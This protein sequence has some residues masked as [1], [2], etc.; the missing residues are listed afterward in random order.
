MVAF[1]GLIAV[2]AILEGGRLG[3]SSGIHLSLSLCALLFLFANL[4]GVFE[5]SMPGV[6]T[7][8]Q[9]S[10]AGRQRF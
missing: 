6:Q 3:F 2:I 8:I 7:G 5:I 1:A 4:L 10:N 9:E